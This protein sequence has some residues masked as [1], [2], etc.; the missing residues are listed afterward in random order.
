MPPF[1]A[2]FVFVPVFFAVV[3]VFVDFAPFAEF[4][5]RRGYG[6][7]APRLR[8]LVPAAVSV[9]FSG[10]FFLGGEISRKSKKKWRTK[11]PK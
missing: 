4:V 10:Q 2:A 1:V 7:A 5:K 6:F 9:F 8:L 3:F 11:S